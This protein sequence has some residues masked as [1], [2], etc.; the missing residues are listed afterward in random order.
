MKTFP[1]PIFFLPKENADAGGKIV[2][3][4]RAQERGEYGDPNE[5]IRPYYDSGDWLLFEQKSWQSEPL[6]VKN[7][8]QD[9]TQ[10]V[11]DSHLNYLPMFTVTNDFLE[12]YSPGSSYYM[13]RSKI[14]G[15]LVLARLYF[16][17]SESNENWEVVLPPTFGDDGEIKQYLCTNT[18][19]DNFEPEDEDAKE[20]FDLSI[21]R[22]RVYKN[23]PSLPYVFETQ[24]P[25]ETES[26][27]NDN[28]QGL[29]LPCECYTHEMSVCIDGED[30]EFGYWQRGRGEQPWKWK[31][32]IKM[33]WDIL[34][35][36]NPYCD[37]IILNKH[38]AKKLRDFLDDSLKNN[39]E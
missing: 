4:S 13:F 30:V 12:S 3:L 31:T 7:L 23:L 33:V 17:R 16:V 27:V 35:T 34:A 21:K 19:I 5:E 6:V 38:N 36:G 26:R 22:C 37:M 20:Y 24:A 32:R 9:I 39:D 18:F 1:E 15:E 29:R 8:G 14:S 25:E 10:W 11:A 2:S 28:S